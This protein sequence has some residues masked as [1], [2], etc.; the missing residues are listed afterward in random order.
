MQLERIGLVGA[1]AGVVLGWLVAA[2]AKAPATDAVGATGA[3]AADAGPVVDCDI[4]TQARRCCEVV[5]VGG[6][7]CSFSAAACASNA[8]DAR[9]AY[10]N[11]CLTYL[12]TVRGAWRGSPPPECR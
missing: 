1:T 10:V 7:R 2:G 12:V 5:E 3:G 6:S 9:R 8:G 11:A 4:C